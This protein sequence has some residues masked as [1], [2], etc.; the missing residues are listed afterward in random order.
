[1]NLN[2]IIADLK[3]IRQEKKSKPVFK[4]GELVFDQYNLGVQN[5][6]FYCIQYLEK[7]INEV[8]S[9]GVSVNTH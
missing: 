1:M 5:G 4:D 8:P 3:K 7:L 9:G 6:M 2:T